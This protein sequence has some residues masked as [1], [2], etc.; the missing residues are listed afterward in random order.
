MSSPGAEQFLD[1]QIVATTQCGDVA[2]RPRRSTTPPWGSAE[3]APGSKDERIRKTAAGKMDLRFVPLSSCA[4]MGSERHGQT[5]STL[6]EGPLR[7]R[8]VSETGESRQ[9]RPPLQSM[10]Q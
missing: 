6:F 7:E 9:A 2:I 4:V 8:S 1:D 5:T 3:G 10:G